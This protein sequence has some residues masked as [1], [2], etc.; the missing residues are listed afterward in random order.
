MYGEC[1]FHLNK[2]TEQTY[3][4]RRMVTPLMPVFRQ[5]VVIP[6]CAR[7]IHAHAVYIEVS[8]SL[9]RS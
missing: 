5:A 6:S 2:K 7:N 4:E 3:Y 1:R 9:I 8:S